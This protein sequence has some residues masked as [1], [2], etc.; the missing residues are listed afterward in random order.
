MRGNQ[1]G[2]DAFE[3]RRLDL[4]TLNKVVRS[5]LDQDNPTKGRS[6]KN[7]KP[8]QK[9]QD[10]REHTRIISTGRGKST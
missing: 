7:N 10:R 8:S 5:V 6:Q 3:I 1:V 4:A 9:A 2:Q